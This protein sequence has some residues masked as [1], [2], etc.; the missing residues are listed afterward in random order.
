MVYHVRGLSN[1]SHPSGSGES[2]YTLPGQIGQRTWRGPQSL[3]VM[4]ARTR[5][6]THRSDSQ[7]AV[8]MITR[9]V[10]DAELSDIVETA[11]LVL[12]AEVLF[13]GG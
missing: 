5:G 12:V 13:P 2:K 1:R 6:G 11:G 3:G 9:T 7:V 4:S 10:S 8:D